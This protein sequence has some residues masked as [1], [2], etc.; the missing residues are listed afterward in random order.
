MANPD[1]DL[2]L[3]Y[4]ERHP[5]RVASSLNALGLVLW[6]TVRYPDKIEKREGR[7]RGSDIPTIS[8]EE[9]HGESDE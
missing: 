6:N 5:V 8:T 2:E 4:F 7:G 1:A 9:N 3:G